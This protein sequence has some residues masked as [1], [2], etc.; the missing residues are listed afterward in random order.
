MEL[1][2]DAL[3]ELEP[4][5]ALACCRTLAPAELDEIE[6]SSDNELLTAEESPAPIACTIARTSSVIPA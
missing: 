1:E 3:P 2:E 6:A 5:L 4:K